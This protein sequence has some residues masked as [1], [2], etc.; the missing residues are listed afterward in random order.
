MAA[1]AQL[2]CQLQNLSA[3]ALVPQAISAQVPLK[4][5]SEWTLPRPAYALS[6]QSGWKDLDC[7]VD[8]VTCV[9]ESSHSRRSVRTAPLNGRKLAIEAYYPAL[10]PTTMLSQATHI[11]VHLSPPSSFFFRALVAAGFS[12]KVPLHKCDATNKLQSGR[13]VR[14]WSSETSL[15][16]LQT[17]HLHGLPRRSARNVRE[18]ERLTF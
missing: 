2:C 8:E 10:L 17:C 11:I 6:A 13:S 5:A 4:P 9:D 14:W 16:C 3:A 15:A 1:R 7:K 18:K 12:T